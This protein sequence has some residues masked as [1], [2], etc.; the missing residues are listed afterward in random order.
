MTGDGV[1]L[2]AAYMQVNK[3][4]LVKTD[5]GEEYLTTMWLYYDDGS[6]QQHA[7]LSDG[8]DVLFSAGTYQINGSFDVEKS[9]LTLH[10]T[11]KYADGVGLAEYDSTHDYNIGELG[12]IRVYPPA[13]R[14]PETI[15][16]RM[17]T[18]DKIAQMLMPAFQNY[19]DETGATQKLTE[20][21]PEI[22]KC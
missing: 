18:E 22:E 13:K 6:F 9:V 16:A 15:L 14:T 17:T 8:T 11:Q 19:T 3:Q 5:G 1:S 12:F 20:M 7:I 2:V 10:R 4:K 21:R